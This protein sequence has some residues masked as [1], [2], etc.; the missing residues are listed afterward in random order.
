MLYR[1][2]L[3]KKRLRCTNFEMLVNFGCIICGYLQYC[4]G[5]RAYS[6]RGI[7]AIRCALLL[8]E[9]TIEH[10]VSV[11]SSHI[12][13]VRFNIVSFWTV[14]ISGV[15]SQVLLAKHFR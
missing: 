15:E 4:I 8:T 2:Q 7:S 11:L 6:T 3:L 1:L 12:K 13:V 9:A 14:C 10:V 5:G